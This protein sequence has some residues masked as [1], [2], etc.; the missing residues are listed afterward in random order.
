MRTFGFIHR[1]HRQ[2][3]SSSP[4]VVT[5]VVVKIVD[6]LGGVE[7]KREQVQC[8]RTG[9]NRSTLDLGIQIPLLLAWAMDIHRSQGQTRD[10][11]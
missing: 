8:L 4:V 7:V 10:R 6:S 5:V 9:H 11:V 3:V 1:L 2:L